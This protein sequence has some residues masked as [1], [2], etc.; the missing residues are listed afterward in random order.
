MTPK[1]LTVVFTSKGCDI[2]QDEKFNITDQ[3]KAHADCSDG[4][5]RLEAN[6]SKYLANAVYIG[7]EERWHKRLTHL[8]RRKWLLA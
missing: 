2:Y 6:G 4:L 1:G 8:N 3:V 7:Q 5:Y